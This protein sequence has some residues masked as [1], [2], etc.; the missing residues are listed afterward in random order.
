MRTLGSVKL[1]DFGQELRPLLSLML[2][3]GVR[4]HSTSAWLRLSVR[5]DDRMEYCGV[6]C[7]KDWRPDRELKRSAGDV[8]QA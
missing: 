6:E 4:S 5:G 8:G 7:G 3:A 1:K 2:S